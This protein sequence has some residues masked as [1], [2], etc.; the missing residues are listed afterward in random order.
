MMIGN[1]NDALKVV[2]AMSRKEVNTL[3]AAIVAEYGQKPNDR[4]R[5]REFCEQFI[6]FEWE[7]EYSDI[8]RLIYNALED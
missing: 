8:A 5:K 6:I 4:R 3:T 2:A 1:L 7:F